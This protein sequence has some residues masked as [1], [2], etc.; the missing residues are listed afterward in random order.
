MVK[1]DIC[2]YSTRSTLSTLT[3]HKSV[4]IDRKPKH[5]PRS[6]FLF[7]SSFIFC[8]GAAV[9]AVDILTSFS[10]PSPYVLVV[11]ACAKGAGYLYSANCLE[12]VFSET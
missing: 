4:V 8:K 10:L 3:A 11:S 1:A 6:N 5:R 9:D 7:Y 2:R 12:R